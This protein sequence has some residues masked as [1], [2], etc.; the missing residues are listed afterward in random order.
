MAMAI[1]DSALPGEQIDYVAAHGTSTPKNDPA[2]SRAIRSVLGKKAD[3]VLVSSNKGHLGH[4]ISAAGITNLIA[5]CKA[6][7]HGT[8]PPTLNYNCP[9]PACDLD[10]VPDKPR[11]ADLRVALVNAFGFGGQNASLLL[12]RYER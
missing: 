7:E 10:Y 11:E 9:D 6:L 8:A 3:R 1:Q 12:K 2:E 4:T 5:A